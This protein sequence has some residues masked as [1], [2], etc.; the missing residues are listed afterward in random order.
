MNLQVGDNMQFI[1]GLLTA[2]AFFIFMALAIY[3]GYRIGKK[4]LTPV[5]VDDEEK[6]R[7][8]RF[9]KHFQ[10]LFKYDL[11]TALQR[12]KVTDE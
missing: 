3:V 10:D 2:V 12:K 11:E 6:R 4:R 9:N 5:P 7:S 1:L 8:E